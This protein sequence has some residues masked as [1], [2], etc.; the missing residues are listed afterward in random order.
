M[1]IKHKCPSCNNI[2]YLNSGETSVCAVCER[3]V[4]KM[5]MTEEKRAGIKM[6]IV[7]SSTNKK[8]WGT[9]NCEYVCDKEPEGLNDLLRIARDI[10]KKVGLDKNSVVILNWHIFNTD[11]ELSALRT[12]NERLREALGDLIDA[13][14]DLYAHY[15]NNFRETTEDYF[16]PYIE[17][18]TGEKE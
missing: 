14:K 2:E 4:M 13:A 11:P 16:K 15:P 7:Y 6:Y 18:L 5:D 17:A 9:G 3:G 10:E 12:E 8:D 1:K